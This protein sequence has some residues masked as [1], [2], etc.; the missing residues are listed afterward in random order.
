MNNLF[1]IFL[2][3]VSQAASRPARVLEI[4]DAVLS[5][6]AS[7]DTAAAYP[8]WYEYKNSD[9]YWTQDKFGNWFRERINY[10]RQC[11][12]HSQACGSY[13]CNGWQEIGRQCCA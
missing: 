12:C 8:C 10:Q 13:G 6:V 1:D 5:R 3:R 9:C 4:A 11:C 7:Q 2:A